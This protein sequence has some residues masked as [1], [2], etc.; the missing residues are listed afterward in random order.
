[1]NVHKSITIEPP[2]STRLAIVDVA[3][4]S[5]VTAWSSPINRTGKIAADGERGLPFRVGALE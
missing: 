1:M 3:D 5:Q 4:G 2:H